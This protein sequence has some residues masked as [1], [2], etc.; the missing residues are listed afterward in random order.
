MNRRGDLSL[1]AAMRDAQQVSQFRAKLIESGLFS[2]IAIEE[3]TPTADRQKITVRMTG[4]WNPLV[5]HRKTQTAPQEKATKEPGSKSP[6]A[7]NPKP[8][9]ESPSTPPAAPQEEK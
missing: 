7:P 5:E 9:A 4:Q 1:R 6:E 3:Q 8:P 2:T